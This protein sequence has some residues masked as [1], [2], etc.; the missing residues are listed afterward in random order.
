MSAPAAF[1]RGPTVSAKS[2]SVVRINTSPGGLFVAEST[3]G[4]PVEI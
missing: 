2:S 4:R 3:Q 1:R